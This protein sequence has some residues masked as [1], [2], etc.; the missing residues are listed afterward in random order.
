MLISPY[1]LP[2]LL[3]SFVNNFHHLSPPPI[4]WVMQ[5]YHLNISKTHPSSLKY[6]YYLIFIYEIIFIL[7]SFFLAGCWTLLAGHSASS[8]LSLQS[9]CYTFTRRIFLRCKSEYTLLLLEICW[10][11]PLWKKFRKTSKILVIVYMTLQDP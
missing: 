2:L 10:W 3:S 8:L 4:C 7:I 11:N 6:Y 9:V 1:S 5:F